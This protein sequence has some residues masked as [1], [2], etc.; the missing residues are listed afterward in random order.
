[1]RK[2]NG[3]T[4]VELL[5]VIGIIAVLISILLPA[6]NKARAAAKGVMCSSNIRQLTQGFLMYVNANNG[7]TP[8][9]YNASSPYPPGETMNTHW[10]DRIGTPEVGPVYLPYRDSVYRGTAWHCP[11]AETEVPRPW[12]SQDRFSFHY[13]M[14]GWLLGARLADG[15]FFTQNDGWRQSKRVSRLRND[16]VIL[17]DG[18]L[19]NSTANGSYFVSDLRWDI[20]ESGNLGIFGTAPWPIDKPDTKIVRHNKSVNVSR[21][22]GSVETIRDRWPNDTM[23]RRFVP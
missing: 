5:V 21:I 4:L 2:R 7:W 9:T 11:F 10:P 1:M 17:A 15:S 18:R 13:S 3:F 22:D 8:Y 23:K 16:M 12:L 20:T 14:N 6:L 19:V